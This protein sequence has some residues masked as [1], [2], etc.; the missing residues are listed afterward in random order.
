MMAVVMATVENPLTHVHGWLGCFLPPGV[1]PTAYPLKLPAPRAT[2]DAVL[3]PIPGRAPA[4]P[5]I[6]LAPGT[7]PLTAFMPPSKPVPSFLGLVAVAV[8]YFA[9]GVAVG[10]QARRLER[11]RTATLLLL[12][13]PGA[14]GSLGFLMWLVLSMT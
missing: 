13:V 8:L 10:A 3:A 11:W 4:M 9:L 2:A 14:L 7:A 12:I 6:A 1:D 5:G